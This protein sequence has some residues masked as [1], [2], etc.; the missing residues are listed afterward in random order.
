MQALYHHPSIGQPMD[1][2]LVK[3]EIFKSQPV[4]LPHYSGQRE[5]LLDSF[6][7]FNAKYNPPGDDT[8]QHW[9]MGLYV[10]A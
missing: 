4:D 2:T 6:C 8:P 7:E 1:I 5:N 9:D 10:S 3:L